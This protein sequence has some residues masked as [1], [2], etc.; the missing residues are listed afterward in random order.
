MQTWTLEISLSLPLAV[1][2]QGQIYYVIVAKTVNPNAFRLY[3][4]Q[5]ANTYRLEV[6]EFESRAVGRTQPVVDV[7]QYFTDKTGV[8][9]RK[10]CGRVVDLSLANLVWAPIFCTQPP[11]MEH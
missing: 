9:F 3:G 10:G 4:H 1:L 7:A 8:A 2:G 11:D 5:E 6:S